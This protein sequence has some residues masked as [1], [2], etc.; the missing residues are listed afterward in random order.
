MNIT[1]EDREVCRA[2]LKRGAYYFC[3]EPTGDEAIDLILGAI[4]AAGK[5]YHHTESW[6]DDDAYRDDV[7]YIELIQALAYEAADK[8]DVFRSE[9]GPA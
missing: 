6:D 2:M 1:E 3:F 9:A 7:S 5:G 8:A 4:C